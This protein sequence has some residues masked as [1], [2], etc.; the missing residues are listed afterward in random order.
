MILSKRSA[1]VR[2]VGVS[3]VNAAV[4][5]VIL[6]IAPL[7]IVAVW[8]NTGLVA[9]ASLITATVADRVVIYLNHDPQRVQ[10]MSDRPGSGSIRRPEGDSRY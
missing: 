2:N 8:I 7:G 3:T 1:L 4:T 6:L 10:V 5:L 9:I